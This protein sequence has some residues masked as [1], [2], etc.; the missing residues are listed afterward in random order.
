[1][2][3]IFTINLNIAVV[4]LLV[5][6]AQ[7]AAG[8]DFIDSFNANGHV[9]DGNPA[10]STKMVGTNGWVAHPTLGGISHRATN[11]NGSQGR[12]SGL[13]AST[14]A[15]NSQ[16]GC[17]SGASACGEAHPVSDVNVLSVA[18]RV[19]GG[20]GSEQAN[21]EGQLF[22]GDAAGLNGYR[23]TFA[24]YGAGSL[25][26]L[27]GGAVQTASALADTGFQAAGVQWFDLQIV[28]PIDGQPAYAQWADANDGINYPTTASSA[29]TSLGTFDSVASDFD[30]VSIAS[31]QNYGGGQAAIHFD[32][33]VATGG[34]I[35]EPASLALLGLGG[36]MMLRRR[37]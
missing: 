26:T 17:G 18:T 30:S 20:Q 8:V 23:V 13:G 2:K 19:N 11:D 3:R 9:V 29:Y 33:V 27:V 21:G 37:H 34:A 16:E 1:M 32:N 31:T 12:R 22:F 14:G 25:D 7:P 35:P 4:G 5:A 6:M 36:L 24:T 28:V 15:G 10:N